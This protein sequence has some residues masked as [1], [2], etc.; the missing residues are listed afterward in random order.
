[1]SEPGYL[2]IDYANFHPDDIAACADTMVEQA[3]QIK[4]FVGAHERELEIAKISALQKFG[5]GLEYIQIDGDGPA[6]VASYIAFYLG[7]WVAANRQATFRIV[8][9]NLGFEPLLRHLLAQGVDCR[10]IESRR[11]SMR[12]SKFH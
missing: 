4:I 8:A 3:W 12:D 11:A 1:M 10:L 5:A 9:K 2:L 6:A 7:K